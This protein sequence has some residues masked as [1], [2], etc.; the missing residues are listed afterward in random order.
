MDNDFCRL[1]DLFIKA[2][3]KTLYPVSIPVIRTIL[4]QM[5]S[6]HRE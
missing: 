3:D 2:N 1:Y 5:K 6:T 4:H